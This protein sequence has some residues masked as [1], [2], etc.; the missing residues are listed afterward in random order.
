MK[1]AYIRCQSWKSRL[2]PATIKQY[3]DYFTDAFLI[4]KA[5]RFDIKG[6]KYISTPYKY[7][8]SDMGLRNARLNFRQIEETHIME[9]V[10]YNE[11]C[12]RGG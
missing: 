11:L 2:V 7:Y 8:F 3:L 10:I 12:L 1:S 5:E 6:K 4:S 9:N